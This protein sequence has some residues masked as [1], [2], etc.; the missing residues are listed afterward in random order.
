LPAI[1]PIADEEARIE[2][3]GQWIHH[4]FT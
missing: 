2:G 4:Q 1:S 3:N